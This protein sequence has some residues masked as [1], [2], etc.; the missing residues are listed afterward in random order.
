MLGGGSR[1]GAKETRRRFSTCPV[2]PGA[3]LRSAQDQRTS[4]SADWI[5]AGSSSATPVPTDSAS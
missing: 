2:G 5:Q 3:A 1:S 4:F